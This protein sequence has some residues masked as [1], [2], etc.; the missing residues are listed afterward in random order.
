MHERT[1]T[2]YSVRTILSW[3]YAREPMYKIIILYILK[4]MSS[5]ITT[6]LG[7]VAKFQGTVPMKS[8]GKSQHSTAILC[9]KCFLPFLFIEWR[10]NF[11]HFHM[12]IHLDLNPMIWVPSFGSLRYR[13]WTFYSLLCIE[14]SKVVTCNIAKRQRKE[15]QITGFK[16]NGIWMWKCLKLNV[17]MLN[18]EYVDEI[19]YNHP[20]LI[21]NRIIHTLVYHYN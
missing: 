10:F 21:M 17:D 4:M 6:Q 15:P 11:W 18:V 1:Y 20:K 9:R 19:T 7:C 14:K 12:Q 5:T 16:S 8:D 13:R 3:S 2:V